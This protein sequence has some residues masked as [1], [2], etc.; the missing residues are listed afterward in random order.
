MALLKYMYFKPQQNDS[1]PDHKNCPSLTAKELKSAND[2][3]SN[4]NVKSTDRQNYIAYSAD[5][6]AQIRSTLW[7]TAPSGPQSISARF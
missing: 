5:E 1:L 7:R 3:V 4:C 2:S 6:R